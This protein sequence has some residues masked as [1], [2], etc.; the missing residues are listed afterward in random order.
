MERVWI[1]ERA[2]GACQGGAGEAG[3]C[4][5]SLQPDGRGGTTPSFAAKA[6]NATGADLA[7]EFHFNSAGSG[8]T[9]TE[10][11]C[12]PSKNGARAAE[13]IQTAMCD[14]LRLPDRGVKGVTDTGRGYM[15]FKRQL[16]LR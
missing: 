14:V 6:C 9:G 13:L 8:A 10:T 5:R 7:V 4:G 16:C 3:A 12:F 2:C 1:L 15:Y 11:L